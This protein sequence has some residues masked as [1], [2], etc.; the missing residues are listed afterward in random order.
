[1]MIGTRTLAAGLALVA[2]LTLTPSTRAG[3][4]FRLD[5]PGPART[6]TLDLKGADDGADTVA[7]S[8]YRGGFRGGF[9]Y[10]GYRGAYGGYRGGYYGGYRG[11]YYGGYHR[12]FYGSYYRPFYGAGYYGG[13][14]SFYPRAYYGGFGYYPGYYSS[15]SYAYPYYYAPCS[16]PSTIPTMPPVVTLQAT[17]SVTESD[18]S[19]SLTTPGT[20]I[21]P[22]SGILPAPKADSGTFPYD[23]GPKEAVPMPRIDDDGPTL[24]PSTT[25]RPADERLV[26]FLQP[27]IS[28]QTA[29]A[30]PKGKWAYPAYGEQPRR[31]SFAEERVIKPGR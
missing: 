26:S 11:G 3:D 16:L 12:P 9:Y 15:Y 23:G 27:D 19:P 1:M 4:T 29:G 14:R 28:A 5:M 31:T 30:A 17:P 18:Y 8:W 24:K 13:Y 2:G 22:A 6:T 25:I 20:V 10:G 21:P 7:T